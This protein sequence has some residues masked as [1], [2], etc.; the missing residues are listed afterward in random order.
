M[1][2]GVYIAKV[3]IDFDAQWEQDFDVNLAIYG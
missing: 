1:K 2:P 3:L